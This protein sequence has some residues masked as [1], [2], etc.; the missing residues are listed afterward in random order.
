MRKIMVEPEQLDSCASRMDQQNDDYKLHCKQLFE[1]VENM[2][3]AWIGKDNAEFTASIASYEG[4]C[5]Q[6]SLLCT[7]YSEFL[8]N[9]ARAYRSTQDELTSQATR[10]MK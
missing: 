2:Q 1:A 3:S 6:L 10:L 7:Q 8:K 9:S 4:E 5:D